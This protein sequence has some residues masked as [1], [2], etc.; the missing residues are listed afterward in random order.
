MQITDTH[1]FNDPETT[2]LGVNTRDSF[3]A[4]MQEI[5]ASQLQPD[6]YLLTGDFIQDDNDDTYDV[7]KDYF[8]QQDI[9]TYWIPGNHDTDALLAGRF[10]GGAI[11]DSKLIEDERWQ[12]VLLNSRKPGAVEGYLEDS[13][14]SYLEGVLAAAT[15]HTLVCLHHNPVL[16][17]CGWLDPL[18]LEN[19][20]EF[21]DVID[22]WPQV[23]GVLWGHIHQNFEEYRGHVKLM[24]TPSTS[25]QF[26]PKSKDFALDPIS[27]GCRYLVL[28]D[29]GLIDTRVIRADDFVYHFDPNAKGY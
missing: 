14:L 29:N 23:V 10:S 16:I 15:K 27:P 7:L 24:A 8:S 2:F 19:S 3:T 22:R 17:D 6:C 9:P 13:E 20:K 4:V 1:L 18:G 26:L 25:I 5:A 12:V 11:T 21:W 28:E